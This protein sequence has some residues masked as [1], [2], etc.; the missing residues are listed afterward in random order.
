MYDSRDCDN[1]IESSF[2]LVKTRDHLHLVRTGKTWTDEF[3]AKQ[4]TNKLGG[5]KIRE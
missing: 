4:S 1:G 2:S 3:N 5:G